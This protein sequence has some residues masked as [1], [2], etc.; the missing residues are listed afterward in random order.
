MRML[1]DTATVLTTVADAGLSLGL[2]THITTSD[3]S[4]VQPTLVDI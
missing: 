3:L 1:S 2:S 4:L